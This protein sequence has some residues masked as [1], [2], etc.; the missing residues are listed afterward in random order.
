M[1]HDLRKL[2]EK[3]E[4]ATTNIEDN[5]IRIVDTLEEVINND[6]TKEKKISL[7]LRLRLRRRNVTIEK[8][9]ASPMCNNYWKDCQNQ[10]CRQHQGL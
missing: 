2:V 1:T 10:Q 7:L 9:E 5:T 6:A 4:K 3:V 8:K